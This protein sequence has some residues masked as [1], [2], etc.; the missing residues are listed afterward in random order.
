MKQLSGLDVTL[1]DQLL[2]NK[3]QQNMDYLMELESDA[4]L[5]NFTQEAGRY[6]NF[7]SKKIK[8]GGWE[9]PSCQLRGHFL[10]H[11]LSAAAIH[12]DETGNQALLGKANEI[13]HELRLCQLD[14]G[15]EWAASIP[16]KYFHWI[17]IKKQVWAPHYNVHKTF[18]GLLDMYLY[19]KNEEALTIAI[20]F[21][22]WFLRYT[23]N[24][25][26]EQLDD[27]LDFETGGMLEIWA[28]LYDITKD[29]M[30][31]TLIERYDRHRL[32]DP[33]LAGED[34][35]TNMHAN[36]TIPE[37]IG[38]A[39]VYEA[40]KITRYRDIVLAYWKCAVT[41]RGYFVT[42]G[43]TNGEIW[44]PK[45]RQASRLGE[46]NQ[47]HCSVYNMIRLANIL[48]TWT[49]DVSY[50]N[51]I[52][53]N[54]YNGILAQ[55]YWKEDL[56]NGQISSYPSEGLLTY[57]LPMRAGSRKGWASKTQ[58]FFCCHGSVV[59]ANAAHNQYLYY[60]DGANL[61]AAQYFDSTA[62]FSIGNTNVT[63][64]QKQDSLS[65]SFHIS[66]TSSAEQAIHENTQ[67]YPIQPDC[68]AICMRIE[69]DSPC[70]DFSLKLRIPDWA[71]ART[72]SYAG[73]PAVFQDVCF[74]LTANR[75]LLMQKTDFL[76]F[77]A[78][79]KMV[80]NFA[81]FFLFASLQSL[82]TMIQILLH[83]VL[84]Q[85]HLPAFAVKSARFTH[86]VMSFKHFCFMIMNVNGETGNA[87]SAHAIRKQVFVSSLSTTLDMNLI[88]SIFR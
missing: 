30:Y 7:R 69:M 62:R 47:E 37:I 3:E 60:Q 19:A 23:D 65:G 9:D 41:D 8:H 84:D 85:S 20:D 10:G 58:D 87:H 17:A 50:L 79:G 15:G 1:Q 6:Q 22:K 74:E 25:T 59:Q 13:V 42:G 67:R 56:P 11:W 26:R 88:K 27:I 38:C 52:E 12:Y 46:R 24:R 70:A 54:L 28:Q 63:L 64:I 40:T 77:N 33:L 53:K 55:A 66:S 49:G 16:E 45:H 72:D 86:T 43:Q 36:T 31:L 75:C 44:T 34:V 4:L 48:F 73:N 83:F 18:M 82:Q 51:Y 21:S 68:M 5:Q 61:Y 57:F 32:F 81:L 29:S 39:A 2:L 80:M 14:N 78:T 35:L 71:C 76:P